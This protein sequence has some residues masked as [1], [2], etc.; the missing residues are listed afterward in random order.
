MTISADKV[1]TALLSV[2]ELEFYKDFYTIKL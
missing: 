1:T 2:R